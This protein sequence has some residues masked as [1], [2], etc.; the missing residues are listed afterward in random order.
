VA[1]ANSG[2]K[3]ARAGGGNKL[4][5]KR[6]YIS[7]IIF[8][9]SL[10]AAV[11]FWQLLA[12]PGFSEKERMVRSENAVFEKDILEIE[13]M[14]GS[15]AELENKIYDAESRIS[16]KY[17]SR[18]RTAED[19]AGHIT[20]LCEKAGIK[21][22]KIDIGKSQVLSPAGIHVPAL[23][24]ADV[25]I[26]FE[27]MD[28]KGSAVIRNLE[29]SRTADFEITAFVYRYIPAVNTDDEDEES[30]DPGRGRGEWLVTAKL[31]YYD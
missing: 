22:V 31:Y 30:S 12:V 26:L 19:I 16:E 5:D 7:A 8:I 17:S 18:S 27:G 4:T 3:N 13:A 10:G 21:N 15:T 24:T 23:N 2:Y 11:F 28:G 29:N 14:E 20:D 9:L 6:P 25:T 1:C